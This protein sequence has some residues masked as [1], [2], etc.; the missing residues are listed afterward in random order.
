[1]IKRF[2]VCLLVALLVPSLATAAPK[3]RKKKPPAAEKEKAPEPAVEV[4]PD[5]KTPEG[6]PADE[7]KP[8]IEIDV[9]PEGQP[10]PGPGGQTPAPTDVDVDVDVED[11]KE[12][13]DLKIGEVAI[14]WQDVIVVMR[15]P[16][17]K[18]SRIEL[19]PA[20][21]LSLNDNMIRHFELDAQ[22]IYWLTDVLGVGVQAQYFTHDFLEP[23]DL[24][25]RAYRRLPTLNKYNFAGA[26]NFHYTPFYA[27]FA[28]FNSW[29]WH[30]EGMVTAGVGVT[31]TEVIP[32]DPE[33]PGWKNFNITPNVGVTMRFFLAKWLTIDLAVKDYVF[34]DKFES[35]NRTSANVDIAKGEA[36]D[37][38][39][40]NIM[41][42][43]GVSFWL[44]TTFEY[45][46]F[47]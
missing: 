8:E 44:P 31:Q 1:M 17:L 41:F 15:K 9:T 21:G 14:S 10:K 23:H 13:P 46:T 12:D 25:A 3:K 30:F 2:G 33:L 24:V 27:K 4:S 47:R 20:V 16:F 29:I 22:L 38:L 18:A 32:R 26:V 7:P 28:V 11:T 36:T 19:L 45:T 40:N 43:A 5:A 6:K 34:V 37:Q 39:I 42:S 35:V